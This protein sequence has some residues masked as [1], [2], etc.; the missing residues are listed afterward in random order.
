MVSIFCLACLGK[1]G[2]QG[3]ISS[4]LTV[5]MVPSLKFNASLHA[6]VKVII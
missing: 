1:R 6:P 3:R 2:I 5:R 4:H